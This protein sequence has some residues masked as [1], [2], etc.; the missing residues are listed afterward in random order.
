M[1]L[2]KHLNWS[3]ER[4]KGKTQPG[5]GDIWDLVKCS[6][7]CILV[8]PEEKQEYVTQEIF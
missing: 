6:H 1:S 3:W 4:N 8:W 5:S 2:K 7:I